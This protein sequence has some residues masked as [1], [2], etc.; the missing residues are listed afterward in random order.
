VIADDYLVEL[1]AGCGHFTPEERPD[2]VR[3][4]LVALAEQNPV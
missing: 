4:R 2:Q 3:A 1:L